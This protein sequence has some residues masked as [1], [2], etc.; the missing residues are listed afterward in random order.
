MLLLAECSS[1]QHWKT[2]LLW[3]SI[4]CYWWKRIQFWHRFSNF[5]IFAFPSMCVCMFVLLHCGKFSVIWTKNG[6]WKWKLFCRV[7]V[8]VLLSAT[9]DTQMMYKKIIVA[10][11]S[12]CFSAEK[13][14]KIV[15]YKHFLL[16]GFEGA[17]KKQ[18]QMGKMSS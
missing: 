17:R 6:K 7:A 8:V 18:W 2:R 1:L 15:S 5:P 4:H 14:M 12:F 3:K 16:D 10:H 9:T 13:W 11:F